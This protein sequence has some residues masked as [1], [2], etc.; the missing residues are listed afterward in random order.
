MKAY[1][2]EGGMIRM[3]N[4]KRDKGY[5]NVQRSNRERGKRTDRYKKHK[6]QH[7]TSNELG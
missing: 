2:D 1:V 3:R 7:S 5:Q 4:Y 6:V